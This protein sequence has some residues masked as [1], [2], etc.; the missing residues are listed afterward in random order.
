MSRARI[1]ISMSQANR[2]SGFSLLEVMIAM[3]ILAFSLLAIFNLHSTA[4]MTSARAQ[5]ISVATMLARHQMAQLLLAFEAE[6]EKGR[7]PNDK[8]E[9]GDFSEVGYPDFRWE[10]ELRRVEMPA[11]PLPEEAGGDLVSKIVQ[12]IS[13]KISESTRELKLTVVWKDL[14]EDESIEVIT[15]VVTLGGRRAR[16]AG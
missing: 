10:M 16:R 12:S 4:M 3:S 11:P 15:H 6:S 1:E 9:Q 8:S 14:E 13:K 7:F 2:Q 5:N